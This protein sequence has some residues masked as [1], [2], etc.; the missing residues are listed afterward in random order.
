SPTKGLKILDKGF[1]PICERLFLLKILRQRHRR[2]SIR[3]FD[4]L[5]EECECKQNPINQSKTV[6][7][8]LRPS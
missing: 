3:V 2:Y 4:P 1:Q 7:K 8:H 6:D 5:D